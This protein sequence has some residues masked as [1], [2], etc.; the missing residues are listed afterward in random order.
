ML[1]KVLI[2]TLHFG[3][4]PK[5]LAEPCCDITGFVIVFLLTNYA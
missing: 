3:V 5:V 1:T 4:E 2:N